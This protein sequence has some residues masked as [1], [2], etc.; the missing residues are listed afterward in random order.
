MHG[1]QNTK[2]FTINVLAVCEYRTL[3]RPR[4]RE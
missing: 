4:R 2:K 3:G 1:Q